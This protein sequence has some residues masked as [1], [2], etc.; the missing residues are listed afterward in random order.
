M[1]RTWFT[2]YLPTFALP[3]AVSF[4]FQLAPTPTAQA[5]RTWQEDTARNVEGIAAHGAEGT[6]RNSKRT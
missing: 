2:R 1:S 5:Q 6:A 3:V 4:A